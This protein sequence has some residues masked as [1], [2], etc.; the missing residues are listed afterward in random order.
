MDPRAR[1]ARIMSLDYDEE[2][3]F[4]AAEGRAASDVSIVPQLNDALV[5]YA[6]PFHR[7]VRDED[8]RKEGET[9]NPDADELEKRKSYFKLPLPEFNADQ[10]EEAI[11]VLKSIQRRRSRSID[12]PMS[13]FSV[14]QIQAERERDRI[15]RLNPRYQ[16]AESVAGLYGDGSSL[17]VFLNMGDV[18]RQ[19]DDAKKIQLAIAQRY[20]SKMESAEQLYRQMESMRA[21]YEESTQ[22]HTSVS[23][24]YMPV[25]VSENSS[26]DIEV[27]L[28]TAKTIVSAASTPWVFLKQAL[29]V[30]SDDLDKIIQKLLKL[31]YS[32]DDLKPENWTLP[33]MSAFSAITLLSVVQII[34]CVDIF[35]DDVKKDAANILARQWKAEMAWLFEGVGDVTFVGDIDVTMK[36]NTKG[37]L[38]AITDPI[39]IELQDRLQGMDEILNRAMSLMAQGYATRSAPISLVMSSQP[40]SDAAFLM[41]MDG[42]GH[43]THASAFAVFSEGGKDAA[44]WKTLS[45]GTRSVQFKPNVGTPRTDWEGT[46]PIRPPVASALIFNYNTAVPGALKLV[47]KNRIATGPILVPSDSNIWPDTSETVK[48]IH[49]ERLREGLKSLE[50]RVLR[51]SMP[52]Q[53]VQLSFDVIR[54]KNVASFYAFI[55]GQFDVGR[56]YYKDR[57][58]ASMADA[59]VP[60]FKRIARYIQL[61]VSVHAFANAIATT[62]WAGKNYSF[63]PWIKLYAESLTLVGTQ[64][65]H[66]RLDA[67]FSLFHLALAYSLVREWILCTLDV[68]SARFLSD[69]NTAYAAWNLASENVRDMDRLREYYQQSYAESVSVAW[70]ELFHPRSTGIVQYSIRLSS[71]I[72]QAWDWVLGHVHATYSLRLGEKGLNYI[73]ESEK[74]R[75]EKFRSFLAEVTARKFAQ[76]DTATPGVRYVPRHQLQAVNALLEELRV[77]LVRPGC[78][79]F[80]FESS[81]QEYIPRM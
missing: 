78:I 38:K 16:F 47:P 52:Y 42:R 41:D 67:R 46:L 37:F 58:G 72:H 74:P 69:Y 62:E 5:Q 3:G 8:F 55:V 1:M 4:K 51:S 10:R 75:D 23:T 68:C 18:E 56:P 29:N 65:V 21:K 60:D 14:D 63:T 76:G 15:L 49:M 79:A 6:R 45:I 61:G 40:R 20:T 30:V 35:V 2:E 70:R 25:L 59:D 43:A 33:D 32:G 17:D 48:E 13:L 34:Y 53:D 71:A 26:K 11:E 39:L 73:L 77:R 57:G 36:S 24:V 54:E 22:L 64:N 12:D 19:A 27:L 9:T 31:L 66:L 81:I 28:E 7:P 44:K 50:A 80:H